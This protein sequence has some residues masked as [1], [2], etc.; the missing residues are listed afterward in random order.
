MGIMMRHKKNK[1]M[2][3]K[4]EIIPN[5]LNNSL[6]VIIKVAKPAAVVK[7]V[8]SVAVPTL[9]ITLCNARAL[10]PC[11]IN[12]CWYL[13]VKKIQLGIPMTITN[14]GTKAVRTV[15]SKWNRPR[16]P[17]VHITP[18]MTITKDINVA[19]NE[20]KKKKKISEVTN[21]EAPINRLISTVM[22]FAFSVL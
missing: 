1:A 17:N 3:L 16:S 2:I 4:E 13:L 9:V 15:I 8:I 6:W 20:R 22:L 11:E 12:S 10:L 7:F 19:R 14:E 5:S 18:I 21:R